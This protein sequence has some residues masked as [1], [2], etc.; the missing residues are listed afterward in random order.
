VLPLGFSQD[1]MGP[2]ARSVRDAALALNAI[3][4][5]DPM[6]PT[7]SRR[8]V[9]DYVPDEDCAIRGVRIGFPDGFFFDRLDRDVESA[10]RGAIARAE[11]LGAVVT[12]VRLPDMEALN[13]IARIVLLAEAS[14]VAE[15]YPQDRGL[16]GAD[17]RALLDQGRLVPAT[18]YINAQRLRRQMRRE[19]DKV[20]KEV[21]CLITPATPIPAPRAGD[22][23]VRLGGREED[24]RLAA[25]RLVRGMN[26]LGFPALSLPCG[27]SAAGLPVGMQIIGPAFEEALLLRVGAALEDGG[28]GIPPCPLA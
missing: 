16:Y 8:P 28:V 1:H 14:A 2:L 11:S 17:V 4:G 3:A 26:A 25:T 6:D 10:V 19:F 15:Q 22:T 13:A 23:T 9:V 12:Q 24:V 5:H 21:D 7:C 20:W 18:D 27:L